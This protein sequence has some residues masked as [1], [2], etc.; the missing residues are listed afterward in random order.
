MQKA[1]EKNIGG[2][3]MG[4]L[5]DLRN[6]IQKARAEHRIKAQNKSRI[7]TISTRAENKKLQEELET[8][9]AANKEATNKATLKEQLSKAKKQRRARNFAPIKK[10]FNRARNIA[11]GSP[12]AQNNHYTS[13]NNSP[14]FGG[15]N[16]FLK[17]FD[18]S[19]KPAPATTIK[20]RKRR[21][22]I[23]E[24]E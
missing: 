16:E 10:A 9:N 1:Q 4:R 2:H 20:P 12:L 7:D 3:N 13:S 14:I 11:G 24:Y 15:N 23:I 18:K 8:I 19:N 17:Q 22:K 6:K 21:I 5:A